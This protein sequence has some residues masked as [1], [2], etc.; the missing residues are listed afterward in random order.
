MFS[1]PSR[2]AMMWSLL[3]GESRPASELARI[4]NVSPQTTSN[5]LKRLLDAGFVHVTDIGRSKFYRLAGPEVGAALEALAVTAPPSLKQ[6]SEIQ[7]ARTC[8]DHLAGVLS[9]AIRER[10]Q[11]QEYL[12]N[13]FS[14]TP[15]GEEFLQDL[16]VDI[17][18]AQARRRRFSYPCLDWS[19]RVP[20]VAGA[21]GAALLDWL[22]QSGSIVRYKGSRAVRVTD[23]GRQ[24]LEKHFGITSCRI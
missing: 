14:L 3:G 16:G 7:F 22:L 13:D 9:V 17:A 1:D 10:L 23:T 5:H 11:K 20:H 12:R 2:A 15:C 4:A 21:L 8:Y 24:A 18:A 6:P 19:Q